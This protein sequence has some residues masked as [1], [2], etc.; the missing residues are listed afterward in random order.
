MASGTLAPTCAW[1]EGG[2]GGTAGLQPVTS[3][4]SESKMNPSS[5]AQARQYASQGWPEAGCAFRAEGGGYSVGADRAP[6]S[7]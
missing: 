4:A 3:P 5:F 1:V 7:G 2:G 6:V